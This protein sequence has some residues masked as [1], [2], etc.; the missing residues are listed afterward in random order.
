MLNIDN[1]SSYRTNFNNEYILF[2][3]IELPEN[4]VILAK[5]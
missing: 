4:K 2:T 5:I 1:K 3:N